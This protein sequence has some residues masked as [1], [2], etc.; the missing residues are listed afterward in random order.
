MAGTAK[1]PPEVRQC[2]DP[3][4]WRFGSIAV[5][6]SVPGFAWGVF[7]P[8][9]GGHWESDD[10]TV[11]DWPVLPAPAAAKPPARAPS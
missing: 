1:T 4:D 8:S 11:A 5:A 2:T 7:N 3:D 10:K 6:S 9:S